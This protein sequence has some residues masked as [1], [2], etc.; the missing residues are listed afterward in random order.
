V[1][2]LQTKDPEAIIVCGGTT[3][4]DSIVSTVSAGNFRDV[5]LQIA[6]PVPEVYVI[7]V[8]GVPGF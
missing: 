6:P 7:S 5:I 3:A 4:V 1:A 2:K 8:Q